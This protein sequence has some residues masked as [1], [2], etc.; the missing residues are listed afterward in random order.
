[1]IKMFI[2]SFYNTLIDEEDAIPTTT[3]LAIDQL[4]QKNILITIITNRLQNEVLYYNK[5]YPFI[6]YII[7]LNGSII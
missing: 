1:M 6:D 2:S 3:M 5:D 7:S 4:K